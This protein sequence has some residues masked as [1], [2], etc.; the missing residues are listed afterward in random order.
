MI[1]VD[2]NV[3]WENIPKMVAAGASVLVAGT[4]SLFDGKA[5]LGENLRRMREMIASTR[6]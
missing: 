4:S 1:E 2:G 3:S 6:S 5:G